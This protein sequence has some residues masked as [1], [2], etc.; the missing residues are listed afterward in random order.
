MKTKTMAESLEQ[1]VVA[2][3][4]LQRTFGEIAACLAA[5]LSLDAALGRVRATQQLPDSQLKLLDSFRDLLR[6]FGAPSAAAFLRMQQHSAHHAESLR[7]ALIASRSARLTA[8]LIA[9]VPLLAA[10]GFQ[11]IGI[12][13]LTTL[14]HHPFA[15][16]AALIGA[17]LIFWGRAVMLRLGLR[18]IRFDHR[19]GWELELMSLVLESG[20]HPAVAERAARQALKRM[21]P[22]NEHHTTSACDTG[23]GS[24]KQ[25][26]VQL[27]Q[28]N[29]QGG[30]PLAKL[31][32]QAATAAQRE[33]LSGLKTR[34]ALLPT[35]LL[36]PIGVFVLPGFLLSAVIPATLAVLFSTGS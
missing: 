33:E 24:A 26:L 9:S 4:A 15:A 18:A 31:L 36:I 6:R 35:R 19:A 20:A 22:G 5:G 10:L 1:S 29:R 7:I 21:L 34:I 3:D 27:Y 12:P 25:E 13:V 32:G 30:V 14:L 8:T 17:T 23:T 16:G 28:L 2:S 11:A